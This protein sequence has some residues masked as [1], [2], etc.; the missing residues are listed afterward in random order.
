MNNNSAVMFGY[1]VNDRMF[2]GRGY[3]FAE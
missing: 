3:G 2:D 1:I